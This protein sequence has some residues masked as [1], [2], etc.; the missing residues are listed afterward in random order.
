VLEVLATEKGARNDLT[1]WAKLGGHELV[2][3]KKKMMY[4][5]FG[6]GK[7]KFFC[8]ALYPYG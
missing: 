1:A 2:N 6:S 7:G 4:L 8:N 3:Q 5:H